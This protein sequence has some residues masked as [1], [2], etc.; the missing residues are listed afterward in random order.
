MKTKIKHTIKSMQIRL[1][2]IF[3][4]RLLELYKAIDPVMFTAGKFNTIRSAK[5][6]REIVLSN[7]PIVNEKGKTIS[8]IEIINDITKIYQYAYQYSEFVL[9][10]STDFTI[11]E[12]YKWNNDIFKTALFHLTDKYDIKDRTYRLIDE[13]YKDELFFINLNSFVNPLKVKLTDLK[14]QLTTVPLV[15]AKEMILEQL[16]Q[17]NKSNIKIFQKNVYASKKSKGFDWDMSV[18][19]SAYWSETLGNTIKVP[20]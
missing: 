6:R 16:C 12:A 11:S 13:F 8:L 5:K 1:N 20:L 7:L 3:V 2:D 4:I 14:G 9:L 17:G 18:R 19:G 15:V 10:E